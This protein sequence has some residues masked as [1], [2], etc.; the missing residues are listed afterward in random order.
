MKVIIKKIS[1][2]FDRKKFLQA[3]AVIKMLYL[4]RITKYPP[5]VLTLE[6]Q[7]AKYIGSKFGLTFCNGTSAFEATLFA[8]GVEKNSEVL[9]TG[10][11]FNSVVMSVLQNGYNPK[12]V[13][14]D[15]NLNIQLQDSDVTESTKIILISHL[16]GI[17]QNMDN[18]LAFA[19]KHSLKVIEDCSHAHGAEFKGQK[20]GAFGD[21]A[22][23]SIQGDKAVAGGEGGIALTSTKM[24]FDRM[25]LYGHMGRKLDDVELPR[26]ELFTGI[27]LGKKSRMH[28]FS[29]AL[30]LVDMSFLVEN[31]RLLN[32]Q[33][34][35][36]ETILN[37]FDFIKLLDLHQDRSL[38]GFH[39]GY[40]FWIRNTDD[41]DSLNSKLLQNK[42]VKFRPYPFIN[43]TKYEVFES[44]HLFHSMIWSEKGV[45]TTEKE[46][47]PNFEN[48]EK[49]LCFLD[50][51]F[52][53]QLNKNDE[54]NLKNFLNGLATQSH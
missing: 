34:D 45:N 13:G 4:S 16:F 38:G 6:A 7:F 29:A 8:L 43:Y 11:T 44:S 42:L 32:E 33:I 49:H 37:E 22:F 28:P 27:G 12:F 53:K 17:P 5:E 48:A 18:I 2:L 51:E 23:F 19:R 10:L 9:M 41:I 14:F 36:V 52:I 24:Y 1:Y 25:R 20:V 50:Y 35:K 40:P 31:N 46:S 54:K 21:A 15:E 26:L 47:L 3:V 39:Y 30:A